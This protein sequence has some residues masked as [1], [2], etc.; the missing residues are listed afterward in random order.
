[1]NLWMILGMFCLKTA[2]GYLLKKFDIV[3]T[4]SSGISRIGR[5]L[6]S[7]KEVKPVKKQKAD[8][9]TKQADNPVKQKTVKQ[10]NKTAKIQ[11]PV[12]MNSSKNVR[13]D[14]S[15]RRFHRITDLPQLTPYPDVGLTKDAIGSLSVDPI[16]VDWM[17]RHQQQVKS[18]KGCD[19]Y[20]CRSSKSKISRRFDNYPG[21]PI[22][23]EQGLSVNP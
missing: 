14:I 21:N 18:L 4:I 8:K 15:G 10:A 16:A 13:L 9:L 19:N 6:S 11:K 22:G 3:K 17:S 2:L 20:G 7:S 1:M 12:K 5:L 23:W